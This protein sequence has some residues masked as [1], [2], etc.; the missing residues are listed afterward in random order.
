[1]QEERVNK[2]APQQQQSD[3]IPVSVDPEVQSSCLASGHTL[4]LL[5]YHIS[6]WTY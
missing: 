3:V 6:E 2:V 5:L 1:M 4:Q